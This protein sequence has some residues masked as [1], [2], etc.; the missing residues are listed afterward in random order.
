[1]KRAYNLG[2]KA[3][4]NFTALSE[5]QIAYYEKHLDELPAAV[6]RGFVVSEKRLK[7]IAENV[8]VSTRS[9]ERDQ[10]FDEVLHFGFTE[11]K[12]TFTAEILS[13]MPQEIP[14]FGGTLSVV[15][16]IRDISDLDILSELGCPR[17]FNASEFAGVVSGLLMHGY[18]PASGFLSDRFPNV[19]HVDTG[20]VFAVGLRP[21]REEGSP[22]WFFDVYPVEGN[23]SWVAGC[24]VFFHS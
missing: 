11:F 23:S 18:N 7:L 19:I 6:K 5:E 22:G 24:R 17:L 8:S 12:E 14:S 1:M 16:I 21:S 2:L 20:K 4:P 10:F 3:V 13:A 15:E 9:F